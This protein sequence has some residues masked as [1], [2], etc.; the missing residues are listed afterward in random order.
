MVKVITS[1]GRF[2]NDIL[3]CFVAQEEALDR[4]EATEAGIRSH[5][6]APTGLLSAP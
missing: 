2:T 1:S 3:V 5:S 4:L 6:Q